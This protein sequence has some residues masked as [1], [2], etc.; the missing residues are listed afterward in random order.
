MQQITSVI[1]WSN[2]TVMVFDQEGEQMPAF[3][4]KLEEVKPRIDATF[5]GRWE[6]GDWN[7]SF[8]CFLDDEPPWV[9]RKRERVMAYLAQEER[10][11]GK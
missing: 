6:S 2:G 8:T 4:G 3:Q 11:R 7:T 1:L 5:T 10:A 9:T